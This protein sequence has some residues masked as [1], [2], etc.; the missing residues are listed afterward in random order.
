MATS[1]LVVF[2]HG[3]S[4]LAPVLLRVL[5]IEARGTSFEPLPN[6]GFRVMHPEVLTP[7]DY[8]FLRQWR[9]EARRAL[10]ACWTASERPTA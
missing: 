1:E 7:E 6:G 9:D 4:V 10:D 3:V 8:Q 2:R 5:D